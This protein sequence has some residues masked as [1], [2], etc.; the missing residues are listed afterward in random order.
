MTDKWYNLLLKNTKDGLIPLLNLF[1]NEEE[2]FEHFVSSILFFR[3]EDINKQNEKLNLSRNN[4][5]K[6]PVRYTEKSNKHFHFENQSNTRGFSVKKFKNRTEA[7]T[8]SINND[9]FFTNSIDSVSSVRIKVIIDKDGNYAVRDEIKRYTGYRVSQGTLI[10]DFRNYMICHVWG[11]TENPLFFSSLWNVTLIPNYLSFLTD[12]SDDNSEI[13]RKIKLIIK[14]ICFE[15]YKPNVLSLDEI[16]ELEN[17]R[18]LARIYLEKNKIKFLEPK[19]T[20]I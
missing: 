2:F 1:N 8:F 20:A 10:S 13:A 17:A 9:L 3:T 11:K 16:N 6:I 19:K 14:A 12:K 15:L 7:K 18:I 4:N 5:E